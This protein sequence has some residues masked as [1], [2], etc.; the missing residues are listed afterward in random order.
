MGTLILQRDLT[1]IK[2]KQHKLGGGTRVNLMDFSTGRSHL[3]NQIKHKNK[4]HKPFFCAMSQFAVNNGHRTE[5]RV[6]LS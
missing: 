6:L 5:K 4:V 1:L 3:K 2:F